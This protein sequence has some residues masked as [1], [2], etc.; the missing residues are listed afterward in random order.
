MGNKVQF[1]F[2]R[3]TNRFSLWVAR[4][5][6]AA[7]L[8]S[9]CDSSDSISQGNIITRADGGTY[10]VGRVSVVFPPNSVDMDVTIQGTVV[11]FDTIPSHLTPVSDIYQI[12]LSYPD[13]YNANTA[14][15]SFDLEQSTEGVFI[16]HSS[17]GIN[18]DI[19]GGIVEDNAVSANIPDFSYFF[20]GTVNPSREQY[21]I[22]FQ[23]RSEYSGPICI[24]QTNYQTGSYGIMPVAWFVKK[25]FPN[26]NITFTWSKDYS[27]CWAHTGE[28]L[29]GIL[30][31][32]AQ[33]ANTDLFSSNQ[34]TLTGNGS[35]WEFVNQTYGPQPGRLFISQDSN[36][37]QDLVSVGIGMN[38]S[39][40][41]ATQAEPFMMTS[42]SPDSPKYWITFGN[43]K[44]GEVLDA[45]MITN[46]AQILFPQGIYSMEAVLNPDMTWSIGP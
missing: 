15:I 7:L 39:P 1:M 37:G 4:A 26:T 14:V 23:N 11:E 34:I 21:A 29:P 8:L 32:T 16:I 18:W 19:I 35:S 40:I 28:L 33:F 42:F 10:N 6:L 3:Q 38:S 2:G 5:F 43:Y 24:Y 20:A 17:D 27:F 13:V 9:G 45:D 31:E 22:E 41:Y 44:P 46:E 30:F 25:A 36:I 12:S